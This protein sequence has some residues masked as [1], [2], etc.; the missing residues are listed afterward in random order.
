MG[1]ADDGSYTPGVDIAW[2]KNFDYNEFE[3][4]NGNDVDDISYVVEWR[5]QSNEPLGGWNVYDG[6]VIAVSGNFCALEIFV[7]SMPCLKIERIP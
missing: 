6:L 7:F 3:K 2:I 4:S 1:G 5:D